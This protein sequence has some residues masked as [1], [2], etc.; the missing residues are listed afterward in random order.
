[1]PL[2]L[3]PNC[4]IAVSLGVDFDAHSVWPGSYGIKSPGYLSRGEFGADVGAPRLL[5]L[6]RTYDIRTT[7][8]T[9]THTMETFP[10]SFEAVME[11]GHEIGAHGCL[12]ERIGPLEES[13]ER[14]LLERQI[15]LHKQIVG[16]RPRGYRSPSWDFSDHTLALLQEFEFDW[17]SSLMG[18]DFEPYR[19]R[20]VTLRD[21]G[22]SVFG[23][24]SRVLEIPVSWALDD[25]PAF[26]YVPRMNAG[27]SSNEVVYQRWK[28]HFDYAYREIEAGVLTV[29]LHPQSIGRAPN[30]MMLERFI[31][32]MKSHPGVWFAPLSDIADAWRD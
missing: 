11:H 3:P 4:N 27:L 10:A 14:A 21:E 24:P 23:A 8:F 29:A 13:A 32:Y 17:D 1:M 15:G 30:I 5:R 20:P 9:P 12:H 31:T 16:K 26:E 7:W 25:F 19:P 28:D 18:R 22:G 2:S 6:F